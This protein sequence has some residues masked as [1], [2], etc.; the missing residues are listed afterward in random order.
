LPISYKKQILAKALSAILLNSIG[1]GLIIVIAMVMLIPPVYVL[2]QT[3]VLAVLINIFDAFLGILVDLSFPKLHW[4]TEQRAVKQDMNVLIVML[5][6][7]VIGGLAVF[8]IMTLGLNIWIS[9]GILATLF[10]LLDI[11]LYWLICTY[12]VKTFKKL[13]A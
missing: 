10:G 9:F 1:L 2:L 13:Q 11:L 5:L 8:G 12:G 3:I 4:D 7:S 6:G